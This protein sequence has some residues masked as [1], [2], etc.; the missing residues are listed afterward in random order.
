MVSW[1]WLTP[2]WMKVI[3]EQQNM[4]SALHGTDSQSQNS[5]S[6]APGELISVTKTM[7]RA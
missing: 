6:P 7:I 4:M 1:I 3:V 5:P 2:K